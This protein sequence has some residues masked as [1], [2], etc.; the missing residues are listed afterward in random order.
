MIKF[1]NVSHTY[2]AKSDNPRHVLFNID[3]EIKRGEF[4]AILGHNGSGKSTLAKMTNAML[5][6]REGDVIINELNTRDDANWLKVRQTV[7]MV[8]QNPDNQMVAT[9]VEEDVAFACENLGVPQPEMRERVDNALE[10]VGMLKYRDHACH[11]LSGGQ[12][13]R[14]AIAGALAMQPDCLVLDEPTAMLD[15]IGREEVI[16]TLHKLNAKLGMTIVLVTHHMQEAVNAHRVIVMNAGKIAM[17]AAPKDVFA[18]VDELRE[19]QLDVPQSVEL[20]HALGLP[21]TALNAHECAAALA[22]WLRK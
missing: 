18:R 15:P 16:S 8:F 13:Q 4:V 6:P 17:D 19:L 10:T 1:Q 21:P 2:R 3:L 5:I 12:K 7:G 20:L 22:E 11:K 9:I 14:V